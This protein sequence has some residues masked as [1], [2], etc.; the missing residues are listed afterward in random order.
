MPDYDLEDMGVCWLPG[1]RCQDVSDCEFTTEEYCDMRYGTCYPRLPAGLGCDP[2]VEKVCQEGLE[3]RMSKSGLVW[4]CALY[5]IYKILV[6]KYCGYNR[7]S[8][9]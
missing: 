8:G 9:R 2:T 5:W 4:S 1:K 7:W 6:R 3:R